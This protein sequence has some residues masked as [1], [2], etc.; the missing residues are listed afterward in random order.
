MNA[1]N[2]HGN[3]PLIVATM[4]ATRGNRTIVSILLDWGA[5]VNAKNSYP[6]FRKTG[7]LVRYH[8]NTPL[9]YACRHQNT[10]IVEMLLDAGADIVYKEDEKSDFLKSIVEKRNRIREINMTSLVIKRG[11]TKNNEPLIQTAHSETIYH[12]ASFF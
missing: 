10:E 3:T 7:A 2:Q 11:L 8:G 9:G 5:D 6:I 12:I 4:H 1:N